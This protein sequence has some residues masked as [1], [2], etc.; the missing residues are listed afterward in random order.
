MNCQVC[1][2]SEWVE[3]YNASLLKC[4]VCGFVTANLE[5]STDEL[6]ALYSEKYFKGEEYFDYKADK[7]FLQ[8]NFKKRL[9]KIRKYHPEVSN[10][11]EIGCA[12][13]FFAESLTKQYPSINYLG[14]DVS[15]DAINYASNVLKQNARCADYLT[16]KADQ[17]YSD[18]F[19]WDVIEHLPEPASVIKK[20][21][22]E[23][24]IGG[25]IYITTG[26][27]DALL[28][29]WQKHKWRLIHP[30]SHLHYFSKKTLS[31]LLTDSGFEIV[32]AS[33]PTISRSA[34]QIYYSLFLLKY[35]DKNGFGYK[36]K[37]LFY[38]CIPDWLS[39]PI[40]TFDIMF[41][42]ARKIS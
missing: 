29:R 34:N 8:K 4:S 21:S 31:R 30:P 27:I 41:V 16:L 11:L 20:A 37:N 32:Q 36:L 13:G 38:K 15:D 26:D 17:L 1:N 19:M 2:H 6:K 42:M 40:N 39:V 28:P 33:Y 3:I 9:K 10:V 7:N 35:K 25:H 14:I 12:Y 5:I 23:L 22:S 18:I 24:K